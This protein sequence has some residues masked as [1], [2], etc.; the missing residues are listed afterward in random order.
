MLSN[1][2]CAIIVT[3][4]IG[5][6]LLKC[7][8][9]IERQVA[10]VIIVDNGADD[11]TIAVLGN[12]KSKSKIRIFYNQENVGIAAALNTGVKYAIKKGYKWVVTLD[13]DSEAT[14]NMVEELLCKWKELHNNDIDRIGVIAP[15]PFDLNSQELLTPKGLYDDAAVRQVDRVMSSGSLIDCRVFAEVGFFNE[16]LFIYYVDDDFCLRCQDH[17]WKIYICLPPVLF[18][19]EGIRE[20]RK[21]LWKK[22]SYRRYGPVARYY[23]ARNTMY[24]LRNHGVHGRYCVRILKRLVRDTIKI[25]V[26]DKSWQRLTRYTLKGLVDGIRGR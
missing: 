4:R 18:H 14:P 15:S 17:D 5:A 12:L 16:S 19:R 11:E 8:E 26:F 20:V 25:F 23:L 10:E 9:S 7:Y 1:D 3:Y 24:M 13:H 2:V 22:C 21:F 6:A